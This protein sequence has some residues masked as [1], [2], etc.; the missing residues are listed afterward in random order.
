VLRKQLSPGVEV[1]SATGRVLATSYD[2]DGARV[3][4]LVNLAD[5]VSEGSDPVTHKAL[6]PHFCA[7]AGRMSEIK[8]LVR[9]LPAFSV[10]CVRL[11]TPERED[12]VALRAEYGK[13]G[14]SISI[15]D[16]TFAAY[17]MVILEELS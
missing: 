1:Y 16:D 10:N 12:E 2:A 8:L 6:I 13:E 5:T 15:P 17:A 11:V 9:D 4:H 3:L 7:D 14:L